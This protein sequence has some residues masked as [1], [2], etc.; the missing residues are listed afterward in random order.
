MLLTYQELVAACLADRLSDAKIG[1][2]VQGIIELTAD[3]IAGITEY[4][5]TQSGSKRYVVASRL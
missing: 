2:V 3:D 5:K 1:V 4:L